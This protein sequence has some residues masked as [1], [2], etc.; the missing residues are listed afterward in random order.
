MTAGEQIDP[1]VAQ[2]DPP[3]CKAPD[4]PGQPWRLKLVLLDMLGFVSFGTLGFEK[5]R[6]VLFADPA[7]R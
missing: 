4:E 7:A 1:Q 5:S 6:R 2:I 3:T